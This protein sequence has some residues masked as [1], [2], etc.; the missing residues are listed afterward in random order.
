MPQALHDIVQ[1]LQQAVESD[2]EVILEKFN[3]QDIRAGFIGD[4]CQCFLVRRAAKDHGHHDTGH[5]RPDDQHQQWR[6]C[7]ERCHHHIEYGCGYVIDEA[8]SI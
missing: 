7:F 1:E 8:H 4:L 5:D 6:Q 2:A 3:R